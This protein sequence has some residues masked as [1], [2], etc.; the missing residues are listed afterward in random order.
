MTLQLWS[1]SRQNHEEVLRI[2]S[3][4]IKTGTD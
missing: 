4:E 2:E 3:K 1:I